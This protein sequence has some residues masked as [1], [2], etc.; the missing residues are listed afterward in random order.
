M[1]LGAPV[2]YSTCPLDYIN[3]AGFKVQVQQCYH[4]L[5]ALM[6]YER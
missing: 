1:K 4:S 5:M 2:C 3:E 6:V